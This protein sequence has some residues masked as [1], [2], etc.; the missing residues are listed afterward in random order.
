M[1]NWLDHPIK[2]RLLVSTGKRKDPPEV[3]RSDVVLMKTQ[4]LVSKL[5]DM[6]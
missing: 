1:G 4:L 6:F 2:M 3:F 5:M